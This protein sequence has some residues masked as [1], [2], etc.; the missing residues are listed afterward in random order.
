GG[1]IWAESEVGKGS[2]F[3][4]TIVAEP[5]PP[6]V[7]AVAPPAP[8]ILVGKRAL[9]VDDNRT[10]RRILKLQVEKGGLFARE[11]E[12]PTQA[13]E[14]IRQG[15]PYDIGLLDYQMPGMDGMALAQAIRQ[16]PG[17]PLPAL[18]LLSS[19]GQSLPAGHREAG[20]A[21]ILS[22]PLKL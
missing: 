10:N 21:A 22:K 5:A 19:I 7:A 17:S 4:F 18:I 6:P 3:H 1:R 16:L 9:I 8:S 15:D 13:L 11:T 20:F 2:T 14:W 12:S